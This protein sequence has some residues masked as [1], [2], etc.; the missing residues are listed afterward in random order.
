[1]HMLVLSCLVEQ[2]TGFLP[3]ALRRLHTPQKLRQGLAHLLG[4]HRPQHITV[5]S[6]ARKALGGIGQHLVEP[7]RPQAH[8]VGNASQARIP[9]NLANTIKVK[10]KA[11]L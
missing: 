3:T 8:P 2:A 5:G 7:V 4:I 1:M 10:I 11:M 6:R 9:A